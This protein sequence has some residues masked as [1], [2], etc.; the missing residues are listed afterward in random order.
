M[1][2]GIPLVIT[3]E[4]ALLEVTAGHATVIEG[5]GPSALARAVATARRTTP[6]ALAAARQHAATFTWS[7]FAADVRTTLREVMEQ[8]PRRRPA[9][10]RTRV[11]LAGTFAAAT[12][13]LGG[14][15]AGAYALTV[16]FRSAPAAH[17][18]LTT[19]TAPGTPA[20]GTEAHAGSG[21]TQGTASTSPGQHS[22][23]GSAP[24]AG[25]SGSGSSS[26]T[27]GSSGSPP[28][29]LNVP[30]LPTV[31][32]VTTPSVTVPTVPST[33]PTV[34]VPGSACTTTSAVG[35]TVVT[36]PCQVPVP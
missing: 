24:G 34:T 19:T 2:L 27:N 30:T 10:A 3:P 36:V 13:A 20:P 1:R 21:S 29:N 11:R 15:A 26:R 9:W 28:S 16:P 31:P 5:H 14:A 33:V 17:P 35:T 12:L 7:H 25:S 6:E 32:T 4:P 18:V 22:S 8:A 23:T